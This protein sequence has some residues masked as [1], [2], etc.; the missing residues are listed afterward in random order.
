[1]LARRNEDEWWSLKIKIIREFWVQNKVKINN[2]PFPGTVIGQRVH[3]RRRGAST[4]IIMA[5]ALSYFRNHNTHTHTRRNISKRKKKKLGNGMWHKWFE[6][7]KRKKKKNE[8]C[9]W[10]EVPLPWFIYTRWAVSLRIGL[11]AQVSYLQG[12]YNNRRPPSHHSLKEWTASPQ[13]VQHDN[14]GK[15]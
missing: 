13:C 10:Q 6:T 15:G 3:W 4:I 11:S 2:A 9:Q 5:F 14:L 7:K 1:M 8:F 12:D